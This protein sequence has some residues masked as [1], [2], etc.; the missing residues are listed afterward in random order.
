MKARDM[1]EKKNKAPTQRVNKG[2]KHIVIEP[3]RLGLGSP[4]EG[5]VSYSKEIQT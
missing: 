1:I 4:K 2:R 3:G 5:E